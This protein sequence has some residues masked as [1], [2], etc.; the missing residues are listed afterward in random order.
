M[1]T[2]GIQP[3]QTIRVQPAE[4]RVGGCHQEPVFEFHA[5]ISRGAGAVSASR[6]VFSVRHQLVSEITFIHDTISKA[7]MKKSSL[8]KLPDLSANWSRGASVVTV[9]GTPGAISGPIR[10]RR[11]PREVMTAPDVY[12]PATM[13]LRTPLAMRPAA[14]SA[15]ACSTRVPARR[16]PSSDCAAATSSGRAE[17]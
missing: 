17:E 15:S 12:P 8:P 3:R 11:I 9:Q 13:S 4:R 5:E 7:L 2:F 6:Q 1:P 14:T 10:S 16:R